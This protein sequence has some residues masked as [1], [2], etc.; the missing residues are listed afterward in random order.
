M[1]KPTL[2]LGNILGPEGNAFVILG[3]AQ[4]V[5]LENKMDWEAISADAK[6][7]DY[8]HLIQVI[9]KNFKVMYK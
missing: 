1:S 9:E 2:R 6:S 5:A 8:T 3:R 7:S 4:A